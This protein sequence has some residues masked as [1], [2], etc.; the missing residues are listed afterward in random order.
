M[1]PSAEVRRLV[2]DRL[3]RYFDD[4]RAQ[5]ER[6]AP[7]APELVGAIAALTL[8][9]G[10]RLRPALLAAAY[11]AADE[12][13]P[14]EAVIDACC[15]LELLQTYL[16]VHDDWMDQDDERRGGPSV[17][18]AMLRDA[19]DGDAHLGASLGVLAGDLASAYASELLTHAAYHGDAGS[20]SARRSR[21]VLRSCSSE[22]V[23][24]PAARPDRDRRRRAKM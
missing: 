18:A 20:R 14:I 10:K 22:V 8:R 4:K 11:R 5:A 1:R 16:L 23:L 9:G 13:R 19:H 3:A 2:E 24:R 6:L 12:A 15:A 7:E 17:L 21:R